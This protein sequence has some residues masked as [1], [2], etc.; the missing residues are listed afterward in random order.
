MEYGEFS[1]ILSI[2][3]RDLEAKFKLEMNLLFLLCQTPGG[4]TEYDI[5][6]ICTEK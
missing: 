6:Y 4:I 3:Y 1:W 5:E 2:T